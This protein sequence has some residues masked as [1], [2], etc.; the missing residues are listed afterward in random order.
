MPLP[1]PL[2]EDEGR[3]K[4]AG[5]QASDYEPASATIGKFE[6]RGVTRLSARLFKPMPG[7]KT[8]RGHGAMTFITIFAATARRRASVLW[9][10]NT[11]SRVLSFDCGTRIVTSV[12]ELLPNRDYS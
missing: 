2:E 5:S 6:A 4:G 8:G 1:Q 11:I 12:I 10:T 9:A 3:D 7:E